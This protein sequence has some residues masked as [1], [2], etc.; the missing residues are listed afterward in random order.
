MVINNVSE[1]EHNLYLDYWT[2][3]LH[4]KHECVKMTAEMIL[5]N[6]V[7]SQCIEFMMMSITPEIHNMIKKVT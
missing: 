4:W 7:I 2:Y 5:H 3:S 1:I 6:F